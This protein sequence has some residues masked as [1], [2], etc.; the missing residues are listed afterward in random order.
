MVLSIYFIRQNINPHMES[1][2]YLSLFV[3]KKTYMIWILFF[4][5]QDNACVWILHNNTSGR[6]DD[7]NMECPITLLL[8]YHMVL[9]HFGTYFR[10][11]QKPVSKRFEVNAFSESAYGKL[12]IC[13]LFQSIYK[14][15]YRIFNFSCWFCNLP[16]IFLQITCLWDSINGFRSWILYNLKRNC[17]C[18]S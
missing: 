11:V 15:F 17:I 13:F 12:S 4:Y 16:A 10:L 6:S 3:W 18:W 8:A 7:N 5:L 14:H 9:H 1:N 2:L